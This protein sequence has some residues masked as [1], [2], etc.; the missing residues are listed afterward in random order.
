MNL[1]TE[2]GTCRVFVLSTSQ[3]GKQQPQGTRISGN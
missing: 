1:A 3:I 2:K